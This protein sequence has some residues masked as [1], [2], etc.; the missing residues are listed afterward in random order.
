MKSGLRTLH[1]IDHAIA[2]TRASI[3]AAAAMPARI[4]ESMAELKRQQA[5]AF[6]QIATERL[7]L[8]KEG[9]GGDL[10]YIDRQAEK[11]LL[12]QA[13][14]EQEAANKVNKLAKAIEKLEAKRRAQEEKVATAID[15]YDKRTAEVELKFIDDPAYQAQLDK[16]QEAE[17]QIARGHEKLSLAIEDEKIKGRP[18]RQDPF[19]SYLQNRRYGTDKP[20][21]WF[22]TRAL[23]HWVASLC[24]YKTAVKY[25][26]QI[27]SIPKTLENHIEDLEQRATQSRDNLEE[28][29]AAI[30]KHE[31]VTALRDKSLKAQQSLDKIDQEIEAQEEQHEAQLEDHAN[32][33]SGTTGPYKE[34]VDLLK[35][36]LVKQKIRKLKYIASQTQSRSDDQA[37]DQLKKLAR[38]A[39]A[40]EDDREEAHDLVKKYRR[41]LKELKRIRSRY[42][43]RRYDSPSSVIRGE[44]L[45]GAL[46][47]QVLAGVLSGNDFWRQIERAQ[48]TRRRYSDND[49]GGVDWTE[50]LRLPRRSGGWNGSSSKRT[51]IPR[52]PRKTLPRLKTTKTRK[53]GF[54]TGGGF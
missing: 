5:A 15:A 48:R 6:E 19:F 32:L 31:G 8:L 53:G 9:E 4:A 38:S 17:A 46:L 7:N 34:A 42:K 21:G 36:A 23:D 39:E 51:S 12:A 40:L 16:V 28:V 41:T 52:R 27:V 2:Q 26:D 22:L 29:E 24:N 3:E 45:V 54:S 33:A 49:F 10:G 11:L 18:Y 30:L 14:L 37:I 44:D 25:Y 50:G 20:K 43:K 13:R 35:S 47:R 1:D